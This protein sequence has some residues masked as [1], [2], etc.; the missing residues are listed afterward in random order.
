MQEVMRVFFES[1]LHRM[2]Y[3]MFLSLPFFAL[4]LKLLY[5]RRK[6]F[7]YSD[8]AIFTLYH[9]IFSF[10]ILLVIFGFVALQDWL[11]WQL[12]DWI[13]S[14]LFLFWI[15]YLYKSLRNFYGQ[16]RA[17][18]LS[19]FLLLNLLGLFAML[20]LFVIFVFFSIFQM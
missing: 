12:F 13:R 7:F 15:F 16:S 8:H 17:K 5:I 11:H 14:L 6:S 4:I 9:Y 3:L 20:L 1:F 10:F 18:T 2:P 19:K